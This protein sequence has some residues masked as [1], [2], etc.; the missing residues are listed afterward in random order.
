[1]SARNPAKWPV[2]PTCAH[3][4]K[5]EARQY[6]RCP[7]CGHTWPAQSPPEEKPDDVQERET[8]KALKG[9]MRGLW[10]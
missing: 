1:M 5:S 4:H 9:R 8:K 2:C 7:K 6:H 3:A 10:D